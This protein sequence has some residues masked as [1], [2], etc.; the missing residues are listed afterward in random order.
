MRLSSLF[1]MMSV[2]LSATNAHG[3]LSQKVLD[4]PAPATQE[5][6]LLAQVDTLCLYFS[7]SRIAYAPMTPWEGK[8][9]VEG[10]VLDPAFSEARGE[11]ETFVRRQIETF[12]RVLGERLQLF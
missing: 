9:K 7:S 10:T 8:V 4:R 6:A 3:K 5:T 12:G 2:V 11:L 1:L